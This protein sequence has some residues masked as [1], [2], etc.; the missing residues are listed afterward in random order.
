MGTRYPCEQHPDYSRWLAMRQRCLNPNNSNYCRY[1]AKGI[2]IA[3]EFASFTVFC[4]YISQ[5]PGYGEPGV[6]LDRLDGRR[7]YEPGNLRWASQSVQLANQ[8]ASGKGQNKYTGV[9]WSKTHQRWVARV[10]LAG[11]TLLSKVCETQEAALKVRNRFIVEYQLPH[12]IQQWVG[13]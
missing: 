9:N 1:G 10:T 2:T 4:A 11:K 12:P 5:L 7:G 3:P 8:L 6:S 13:E